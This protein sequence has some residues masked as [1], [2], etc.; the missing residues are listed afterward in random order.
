MSSQSLNTGKNLKR[1]MGLTGAMATVV[2][3]TLGAGLFVTLGT[4]SA[5][6]GPSIIFVVILAGIIALSIATNYSWI[7]TVFP[8][9]G[10]SYTYISRTYQNRL[11]GFVVTWTK[12][13]GFMAADAVLAIGFG[14]YLQVFY[15]AIDPTI[16]GF[17]LLSVL[18]VVNVIGVSSYSITQDVMFGLLILSILV[19]VLPGLGHIDTANYTPFFTGG[20]GGFINAAFPMFY[21]YVGIAVA[22]QMGAEIKRPERNLPLSIMGG[23]AILTVLYV[24]TAVVIY[25]V[26]SDY[27]VL[28]NSDRP[29]VTASKHFLGDAGT[30]IVAIG[31]L[32]ATASS[33]HAVMAA[34]I[35][36]PYSWSWDDIFPR[37][38]S[39]VSQRFRTP[40]WSLLTLYVI[41]SVLIFWSGGLDKALDIATFSYLIAYLVVSATAGYIYM[42][43]PDISARASFQP[44]AWFYLSVTIAV[45][46][47]LTLLS[48]AIDWGA[49]FSG[50]FASLPTLQIYIPWLVLGLLVFTA[51]HARGKQR[52]TDVET[53]LAGVPGDDSIVHTFRSSE[54]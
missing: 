41:S 39:E 43:R 53:L 32:L 14:S 45:L 18:F 3:G 23:T 15:P 35:K 19:L 46:G 38:Y 54:H 7:A 36:M 44:G 31:G 28:A 6:T 50:D 33:V 52:G 21:A 22:G 9:A 49:L 20:S 10:G 25:G 40:H 1:S 8:G 51:F 4:A 11:A 34:A 47:S 48:Q 29:L 24:L 5:T 2:A 17:V 42:R 12:W 27:H 16:A 13:L 30:D 26:V 37:H